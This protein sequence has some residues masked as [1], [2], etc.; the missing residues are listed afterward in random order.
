MTD[1]RPA[2]Q[3][4]EGQ[5][6]VVDDSEMDVPNGHGPYPPGFTNDS[7]HAML[8]SPPSTV[9][10]HQMAHPNEPVQPASMS[11]HAFPPMTQLLDHNLDWDPFG[12][13]ASMAF[14]NH[15]QPFQFDQ[16]SMR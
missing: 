5:C 9:P 11:N 12:L 8:L 3:E 15:H 4:Y 10:G 6:D 1:T 13:S 2:D 14:P 16:A 7:Q